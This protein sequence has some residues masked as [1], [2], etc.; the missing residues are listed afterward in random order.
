MQEQALRSSEGV[1]PHVKTSYNGVSIILSLVLC[2]A[3]WGCC[4]RKSLRIIVPNFPSH[5]LAA[6]L[7][8]EH[9]N[10]T[11]TGYKAGSH[12]CTINRTLK[13]VTTTQVVDA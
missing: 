3:E 1:A 11:K 4:H 12:D 10:N 8:G 7:W 2:T 13:T 6:I 5:T 9:G